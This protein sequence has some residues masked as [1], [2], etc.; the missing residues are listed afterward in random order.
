MH[1]LLPM[2]EHRQLRVRPLA[3]V[4][5]QGTGGREGGRGREG[6]GKGEGGRRE[7]GREGRAGGRE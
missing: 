6:G 4:A 2:V 5:S 1:G 7:G 3:L